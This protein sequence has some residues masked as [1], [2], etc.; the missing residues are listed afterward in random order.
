VKS[1]IGFIAWQALKNMSFSECKVCWKCELDYYSWLFL[2]ILLIVS[3]KF[4]CN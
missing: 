2:V 3:C 4:G 1:P